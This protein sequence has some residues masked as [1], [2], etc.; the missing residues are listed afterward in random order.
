MLRKLLTNNNADTGSANYIYMES[1]GY[2]KH[3]R[4]THICFVVYMMVTTA[5]FYLAMG[6]WSIDFDQM[7]TCDGLESYYPKN[8]AGQLCNTVKN[9][10]IMGFSVGINWFF[11]YGER[12]KKSLNF[13]DGLGKFILV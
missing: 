4:N 7:F 5:L 11:W 8:L 6:L 1:D 2:I 10:T 12:M 3:L 13:S 9:L